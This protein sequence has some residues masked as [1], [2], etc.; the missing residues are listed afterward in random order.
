MKTKISLDDIVFEKRNK[1]YGAFALRQEYSEYLKMAFLWGVGSIL[2]LFGGAWTFVHHGTKPVEKN[3][4]IETTLE[5]WNEPDEPE[6]EPP[7][8]P[9]PPVEEKSV[10]QEETI[11]FL[12]PEPKADETVFEEVTPP[13]LDQLH[14]VRISNETREG[15]EVVN[16]FSAPP[17]LP[18]K[19]TE[20]IGLEETEES[21]TFVAVEQMPEFPGGVK[22]MYAF[23]SEHMKYPNA[24]QRANVSGKVYVKFA[25]EKDGQISR[26]SVLKSVGFGCDDEA[27]RV[28]KSMPKWNPGRQNGKSVPVWFTLPFAFQLD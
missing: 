6:D 27:I 16:M 9:P 7:I 26:I 10:V 4:G 15:E 18:T 17:P 23:I 19:V 1:E 3:Y 5:D 12:P 28:I 8:V 24:A 20:V 22:A 13:S 14:G 25:V 11:T 2:L 21:K